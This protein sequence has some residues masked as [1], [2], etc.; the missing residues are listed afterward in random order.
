MIKKFGLKNNRVAIKKISKKLHN[1]RV[2]KEKG[3]TNILID[4]DVVKE[5]ILLHYLTIDNKSTGGYICQLLS[6]FES[7]KYYYIVMEYGGNCNLKQ[8]V[9]RAHH[10]I[11]KKL[12]KISE[13]QKIC[14]FLFW[15]SH[16]L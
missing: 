6:F 8:F 2:Y 16:H 12:L 1:R 10:F 14:K 3:G 4:E 9:K 15:L 5:A 11:Q 7:P 13:W